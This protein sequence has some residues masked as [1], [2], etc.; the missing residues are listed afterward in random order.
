MQHKDVTKL[1]VESQ[2]V[3]MLQTTGTCMKEGELQLWSK[4]AM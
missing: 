3:V 2:A 4:L 1:T